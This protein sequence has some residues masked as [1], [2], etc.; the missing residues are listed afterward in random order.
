MYY[1]TFGV[2]L[3]HFAKADNLF[4]RIDNPL[5][6]EKSRSQ[7]KIIA[8]GSHGHSER[9]ITNLNQQRFLAHE[10]ILEAAN[11]A[12]VPLGYVGRLRRA[13]QRCFTHVFKPQH[14]SSDTGGH[15]PEPAHKLQVSLAKS[16]RW[17]VD[18]D[19]PS[20]T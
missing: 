3:R 9:L 2:D 18:L 7:I 20:G 13:G 5:G 12:I 19:I 6:E 4:A 10:E 8:G 17:R 16:P 14:A 11:L 15:S 1:R